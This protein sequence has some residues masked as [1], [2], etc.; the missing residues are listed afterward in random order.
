MR[1]YD[2]KNHA[3]ELKGSKGT[4]YTDDK[5]LFRGDGYIAIKMFI[6]KSNH[7]PSVVKIF[8]SQLDMREDCKYKLQDEVMKRKKEEE[9][10]RQD[11]Q[12]NSISKKKK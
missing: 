9:S 8:K 6:D 1:R 2:Y 12:S 7:D 4:V 11:Y 10:R 3:L 5:L